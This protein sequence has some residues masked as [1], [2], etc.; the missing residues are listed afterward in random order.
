[1]TASASRRSTRINKGNVKG[2]KLAYAVALG[3]GAGNEFSEATPLAEDG[4]LYVT[5]SW[6]VLYK[7]DG[8][9][10][11]A[12]RIVWRMDPKQEKQMHNRGA[13]LLGQSRHHARRPARRA[14]SRP[15][16]TPARSSGK[17]MFLGHAGRDHHGAPLA[18]KDKIIVGAANGDTGVRDWIAGLDATT[19]KRA[20]AEVHHS[21][22]GRTRQR[23][24]E[25]HD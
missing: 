23:D 4:F 17:P 15:T 14:S 9:S 19:G 22:A 21:G 8:T 2:L 7:I 6:G 16:K 12:G 1:M 5:D 20:V 24:L 25:G 11:D 10:G 18:I 3:G 13:A